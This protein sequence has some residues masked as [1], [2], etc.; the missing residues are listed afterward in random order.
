MGSLDVTVPTDLSLVGQTAYVQALIYSDADPLGSAYFTN[1][2]AD[3]II[4]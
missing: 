4:K 2:T 3:V 1:Y